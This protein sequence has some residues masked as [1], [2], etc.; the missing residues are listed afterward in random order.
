MNYKAP[1]VPSTR[2]G[3]KRCLVNLWWFGPMG[4]SGWGMDS[5]LLEMLSS[6]S[7]LRAPHELADTV[8]AAMSEDETVP[9]PTRQHGH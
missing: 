4:I 1:A 6:A 7:L 2:S 8:D 9:D 5:W 3:A